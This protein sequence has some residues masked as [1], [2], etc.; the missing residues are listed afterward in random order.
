[1][2]LILSKKKIV[3]YIVILKRLLTTDLS[4]VSKTMLSTIL[5]FAES[6]Y[7]TFKVWK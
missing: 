5:I 7:E 3:Y 1:M 2:D 4:V 6:L